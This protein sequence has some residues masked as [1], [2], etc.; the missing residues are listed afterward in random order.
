MEE[1]NIKNQSI[2]EHKKHYLWIFLG[3]SVIVIVAIMF[4]S[5]MFDGEK[6]AKVVP[7]SVKTETINQDEAYSPKIDITDVNVDI[8]SDSQD[9]GDDDL[10]GIDSFESEFES[11]A[12]DDNIF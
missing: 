8:E 9:F 11:S 7:S 6:P 5:G 3:V 10:S 4:A 1:Q 2:A 12:A